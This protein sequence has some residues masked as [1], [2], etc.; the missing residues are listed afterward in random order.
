MVLHTR[1]GN[2]GFLYRGTDKAHGC[3]EMAG[4]QQFHGIR[5]ASPNQF[6]NFRRWAN[7]S[8]QTRY[9]WLGGCNPL[10]LDNHSNSQHVYLCFLATAKE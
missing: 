3:M 5:D 6:K 8:E 1:L 2:N 4:R 7:D 10:L 9:I